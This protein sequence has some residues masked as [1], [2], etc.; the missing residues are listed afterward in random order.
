MTQALSF[1][2]QY[3]R[4]QRFSLG[5]PR[6]FTVSPDGDRVVFLRSRSGTD[7][8]HLLWVLDPESGAERVAADPAVLLSGDGRG[9]TT[10]PGSAI[11]RAVPA[12]SSAVNSRPDKAN[13]AS[14][15]ASSVA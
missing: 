4:T 2:R 3:A 7:R 14:S 5:A 10:G 12:R 9:S 11:S 13:A 1:P 6:A 15:T 8:S